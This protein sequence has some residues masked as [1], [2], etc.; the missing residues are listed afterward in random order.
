MSSQFKA[1]QTLLTKQYLKVC[2]LAIC[3]Y[4][5]ICYFLWVKQSSSCKLCEASSLPEWTKI[6]NGITVGASSGSCLTQGARI[7]LSGFHD[8][9]GHNTRS[10]YITLF[11]MT[12]I[13]SSSQ[14]ISL[15]SIFNEVCIDS[16][17]FDRISHKMVV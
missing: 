13:S 1:P 17:P 3:A 15:A 6:V 9:E 5:G 10:A 16:E 7:F 2:W 11:V 14:V 12:L 8:M 4:S